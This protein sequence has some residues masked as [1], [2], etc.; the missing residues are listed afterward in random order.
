MRP[1]VSTVASVGIGVPFA[2]I[3]SWCVNTFAGVEM[4]GEVQAAFGAIVSALVG[5]LFKGGKAVDTEE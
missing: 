5:Y 2:T 4:P 3:V 1:S